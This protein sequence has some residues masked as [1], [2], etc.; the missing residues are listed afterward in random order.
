MIQ[1]IQV[2]QVLKA[3]LVLVRQVLKA[4]LVTL[5]IK[6]KREKRVNKVLQALGVSKDFKVK[7]V[8]LVNRVKGVTLV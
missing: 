2:I 4:Q 1:D 6:V 5:V 3:Q 8:V 7:L